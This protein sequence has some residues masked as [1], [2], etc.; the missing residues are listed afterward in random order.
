MEF[1]DVIAIDETSDGISALIVFQSEHFSA[2]GTVLVV[3]CRA[4]D[5]VGGADLG[6]LTPVIELD[7]RRLRACV[8]EIASIPRVRLTGAVL[9]SAAPSRDA[10]MAALDLL[11]LGW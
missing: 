1:L 7:G 11:V 9:G 3:P 4:V 2:L 6:R 10:L 8:P 5:G